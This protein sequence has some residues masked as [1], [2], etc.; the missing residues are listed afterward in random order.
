MA[1]FCGR[2][3]LEAGPFQSLS[4][5]HVELAAVTEG[6]S[7]LLGRKSPWLIRS[8]IVVN[9]AIRLNAYRKDELYQ[10]LLQKEQQ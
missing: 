6:F 10:N 5:S 8:I 2:Q 1:D 3:E 7:P 9:L 4:Q